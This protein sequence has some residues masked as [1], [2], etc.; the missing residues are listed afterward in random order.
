ML[1]IKLVQNPVNSI[2]LLTAA[3]L[4]Q[5][6]ISSCGLGFQIHPLTLNMPWSV[7]YGDQRS[8]KTDDQESQ[9]GWWAGERGNGSHDKMLYEF[10]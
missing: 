1:C 3:A 4:Y 7:L 10:T 9:P 6:P 5:I 2:S 8:H